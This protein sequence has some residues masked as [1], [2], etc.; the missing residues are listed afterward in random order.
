M[1]SLRIQ[2][3]SHLMDKVESISERM[4]EH[5]ELNFGILMERALERV[6]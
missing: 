1:I 6:C 5:M 2:R 3:D 4:M